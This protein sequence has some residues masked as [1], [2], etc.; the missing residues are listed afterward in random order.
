MDTYQRSVIDAVLAGKSIFLTGAG[1]TGKSHILNVLYTEYNKTGRKMAVT[2]LTGCAA[3]LLG[4]HAKT[5]HS[6]AGIGL[7]RGPVAPMISAIALNGRK[8]KAWVKTDCL[9]IDEISMLQP[10]LLDTLDEIGRVIRKNRTVP[11]GG[12]QIVFVGD[13]HQLPP[14]NKEEKT[15]SFAFQSPAWKR[16]VEANYELT[17][18][19][20]Q[21]DPVF[22]TILNEARVGE[23]SKESYATLEGRKGVSWKGKL[24]RPTLLFTRNDNVNE[25][26]RQH[27]EK[28]TG[29]AKVFKATTQSVGT[30]PGSEPKQKTIDKFFG[31]AGPAATLDPE[32]LA[33][34]VARLDK[35]APYEAELT[36][37]VG[38]QVMLL[39][40]RNPEEG[41]VNGS[42]GV[43]VSFGEDDTPIVKFLSMKEPVPV[44][45]HEWEDE[46]EAGTA[47]VIR[48]QIPLRLA[49]ALTIH[50]AQGASL[51]CALVDIG[52]STFEYGQAYVALSRVRNLEGLYVYDIDPVA[53]RVHP[54]VKE[55]YATLNDIPDTPA[56]KIVDGAPQ[57]LE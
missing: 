52:R 46:A 24:I 47:K 26:N 10:G 29:E 17:T 36:L 13:F 30:I 19:Y 18:I 16:I 39:T 6:W 25:L 11:M 9:V 14:V 20:R 32:E 1:G 34:R 22:Q 44:P 5:L 41:L 23:L 48:S 35:D 28:L 7:G 50:K 42:R 38:A 4:P 27:L 56:D 57:F 12:L 3:L 45:R 8:K 51:D 49:Y 53:F 21:S 15:A 2:A 43:I 40:N 37:K 55:F 31:K 33:K 54:A